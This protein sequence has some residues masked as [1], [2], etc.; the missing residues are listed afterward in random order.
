M[1][2]NSLYT[3]TPWNQNVFCRGGNKYAFG[4]FLKP[5][6]NGVENKGYMGNWLGA[7]KMSAGTGAMIGALGTAVSGLG[8]SLIGGGYDAYGVGNS[9]SSIGNTIGSAVSTV[10][11]LVG[12]IISAGSGIIG[13]GINRLWGMKTNQEALNKANSNITAMK[14]FNSNASTFDNVETPIAVGN[15]GTVYKGGVFKKGSARRKNAA[16]QR[17]LDNA[18]DYAYNSV[19]NNIANLQSDQ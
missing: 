18:V 10:N 5:T 17:D 11:P 6:I 7:N 13:G 2:K 14:N 1:K 3:I 19:D 12:G 16:L 9:V 8:S 4:D 15:V